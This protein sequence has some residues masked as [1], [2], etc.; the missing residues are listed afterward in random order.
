MTDEFDRVPDELVSETLAIRCVIAEY[1]PNLC[2]GYIETVAI[3]PATVTVNGYGRVS[4][5]EHVPTEC[6]CCGDRVLAYNGVE[7]TFHA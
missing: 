5:P 6:P 4:F 1:E 3:D 7:V 2:D